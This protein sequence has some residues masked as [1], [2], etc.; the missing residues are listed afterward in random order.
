VARLEKPPIVHIEGN[1]L[2]IA[3]TKS[4]R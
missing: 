1:V 4:V 2:S 3:A